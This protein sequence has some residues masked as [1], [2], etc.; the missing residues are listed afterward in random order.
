MDGQIGGE[1]EE[2][3]MRVQVLAI[4][5]ST[6]ALAG[7]EDG[8][9][10]APTPELTLS[11]PNAGE[12]QIPEGGLPPFAE[13]AALER[14]TGSWLQRLEPQPG[15]LCSFTERP[16]SERPQGWVVTAWSGNM[17][18]YTDG[19]V[20]AQDPSARWI[21]AMWMKGKPVIAARDGLDDVWIEPKGDY[22][23]TLL[24]IDDRRFAC[25]RAPAPN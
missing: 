19:Y 13:R 8:E 21:E 6:L 15:E 11:G 16:P 3:K 1:G 10:I 18:L 22:S 20:I 7:C 4:V 24:A 2:S 23:L 25:E 12:A 17:D 9:A 14:E 5:L